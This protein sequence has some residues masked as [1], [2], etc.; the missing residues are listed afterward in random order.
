M[1]GATIAAGS[2]RT[3]S[4]SVEAPPRI[5]DGARP[6]PSARSGR[7][8]R[9][10][11]VTTRSASR[12][13]PA[14]LSRRRPARRRRPRS[15]LSCRLRPAR[16]D[17]LVP[18][19]S[20]GGRAT[21]LTASPAGWSSVGSVRGSS[22]VM[23]TG[24]SDGRAGFFGYHARGPVAQRQSRRLLIS[25]SWVQVPPGSPDPFHRPAHSVASPKPFEAR[26]RGTDP[27]RTAVTADVLSPPGGGPC[28]SRRL[29]ARARA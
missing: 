25:R 28:R 21:P 23:A 11:E 4:I 27:D 15:C 1:P 20:S 26:T 8:G 9:P 12:G 14:R 24:Y 5:S 18:L 6:S 22:S 13:P 2:P 17:L 3:R 19:C 16:R 10:E 7:Q 29:R